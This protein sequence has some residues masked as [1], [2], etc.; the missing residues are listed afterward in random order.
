MITIMSYLKTTT[1]STIST[2][3]DDE[4]AQQQAVFRRISI[5]FGELVPTGDLS[6][7][8][9]TEGAANVVWKVHFTE[10]NLDRH[11]GSVVLRMRK[12][13]A[14]TIPMSEMK[15][16]FEQ[17]IAPL[18]LFDPSLLLPVHLIRMCPSIIARLNK[19]LLSLE[20]CN[21]RGKLRAN[22]YH[23]S[24]LIEPYAMLMPN[25]GHGPG[26]VIEFKPKW[27]IQSPSAPR[28]AQRCRTCALNARRRAKGSTGRGD[29]GFCPFDLLSRNTQILSSA[30]A[31][32]WHDLDTLPEFV[33]RF[34][35]KVQPA[36]RQMQRIQRIHNEVGLA[37]FENPNGKDFSI[38]MALRD[39]SVLL[40]IVKS[41]HGAGLDIPLIK[42]LDLDLKD[43]GGGK[44]AKW[45]RMESELLDEG[46]Y[47]SVVDTS[48]KCAMTFQ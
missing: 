14:S 8:Y 37:D 19:D 1:L 12:D 3:E 43:T 13:I 46:W 48:V 31:Q 21:R 20:A 4:V 6:F 15:E 10:S 30:L 2:V 9:L 11:D 36:L 28:S 38:A 16:Q 18:F 24:F 17:R 26:K 23:P 29:S 27:L 44:L 41:A 35:S 34:R 33:E 47:T 32:I 45:A 42:F 40:K 39:C 5:Y 22:V 7:S 25:L